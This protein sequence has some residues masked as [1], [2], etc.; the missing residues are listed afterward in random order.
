MP[1][2]LDFVAPA[3]S[4]MTVQVNA[5]APAPAGLS[6]S[7][8]ELWLAALRYRRAADALAADTARKSA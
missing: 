8:Q 7:T 1:M 4:K 3:E 2:T 5:G 6:P